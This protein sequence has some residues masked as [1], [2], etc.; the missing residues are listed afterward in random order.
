MAL[1]APLLAPGNP[2]TITSLGA[3]PP[4]AE[5]LARA[6]PPK[7]QDVLALTMWGA[8]SSLLVGFVVG[9]AATVRSALLVGL[10]SAYF[11]GRVDNSLSLLTNVFLLHPGTAAPGRSSRRSCRP[12]SAP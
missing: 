9:I 4:S 10:S 7:G 2:S 3:Q 8:R 6:P 11:G 12:G 5:H 1:L